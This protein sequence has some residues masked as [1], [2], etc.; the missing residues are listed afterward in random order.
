E[1]ASTA[2]ATRARAALQRLERSAEVLA[3]CRREPLEEPRRRRLVSRPR[4]LRRRIERARDCLARERIDAL[5]HPPSHPIACVRGVVAEQRQRLAHALE[6]TSDA[7]TGQRCVAA[8]RVASELREVGDQSS[9][10][11]VQVYVADET[12]QIVVARDEPRPE[13]VLEQVADAIV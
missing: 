5:L 11:R 13:A 12:L 1:R 10:Q 6:R 8:P 7:R 2:L 3:R 9:V 4:S